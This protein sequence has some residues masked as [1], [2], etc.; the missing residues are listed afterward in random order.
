MLPF[1]KNLKKAREKKHMSRQDLA[2]ITGLSISS[3]GYYENDNREP[4]ASALISIAS[5]LGCSI[6]ELLG[7]SRAKQTQYINIVN[8]S[9]HLKVHINPE[10]DKIYIDR[11]YEEPD[12]PFIDCVELSTEDFIAIIGNA[13][14]AYQA[15]PYGIL[16]DDIENKIDYYQRAQDWKTT[17]EEDYQK[18]LRD[19]E[20]FERNL[21]EEISP[22]ISSARYTDKDRAE[23]DVYSSHLD[24]QNDNSKK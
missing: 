13:V 14:H 9:P 18:K 23:Y 1:S 4:T 7:Y 16:Q 11:H 3:L 19:Q 6:D 20:N 8:K 21:Q 24:S 17:M 22:G 2:K 5:A 12:G 15:D 10:S